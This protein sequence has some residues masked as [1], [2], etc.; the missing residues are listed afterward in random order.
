[1]EEDAARLA[2]VAGGARLGARQ[3]VAAAEGNISV[4]LSGDRLLVTPSGR[5]KDEL[6]PDD[7]MIVPLE[8]PGEGDAVS[9]S[10]RL[11]TSDIAIHR[12]LMHARRDVS[13]VAHGHLPVAM[14]LTLAGERPDP[15]CLPETALFL[16]ELPVVAFA[17]M[18]SKTLAE[19]VA[20]AFSAAI[21]PRAVIL[22][23]HGA[24]AVATETDGPAEAVRQAVDRLE[25]IEV[26]CRAW[27]DAL[28][29][30]AARTTLGGTGFLEAAPDD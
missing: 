12:R 19:R 27:R 16:P 3:L 20:S 13:V 4:R 8:R 30:R 23:R 2:I 17:E 14:A 18:G 7:L 15:Q 29:I 22:E 24:I 21:P 26:L 9:P 25:L 6:R 5:R 28:L 1:V 11:P 10:G